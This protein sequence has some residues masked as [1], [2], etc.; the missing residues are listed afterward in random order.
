MTN[1]ALISCQMMRSLRFFILGTFLILLHFWGSAQH[2][3]DLINYKVSEYK[4]HNQNWAVSQS[5]DRWMYFANTDG[6]LVFNGNQWQKYVLPEHNIIRAVY[7]HRDRVY[8]G[9]YGAFGYWVRDACGHHSYTSLAHLVP[10]KLLDKE[11]VWHITSDGKDV[12]FQ[13]FSVLLR[14]DGQAIHHVKLPGS[15]MFLQFVNGNKIIQCID[16]GLYEIID[17]NNHR[18]IAH[19]DF[20]IGKTVTAIL[21]QVQDTASWLITTASDGVFMMKNGVI[22]PWNTR[23]QNHFIV[24]QINKC[25]ITD[26][27]QTVMGTIRDGIL[28]FDPNGSLLYHFNTS[29]GLQN[30]TVLAIL[31]DRDGDLW[32]SQVICGH[33]E[34][35]FSIKGHTAEKISSV[36]GGWFTLP[37]ADNIMLQGTYTGLV[38]FK[39]KGN[40]WIF[41]N[42]IGQYPDP[43]KK[44][45]HQS[46][47][48]FWVAGP[49]TGLRLI[50]INHDFSKVEN[51]VNY[52][53]NLG[54]RNEQNVEINL[55]NDKL[56]VFDG[57]YH[58]SYDETKDRFVLDPELNA[59]TEPCQIRVLGDTLLTKIY[60]DH[61]VFI[62]QAGQKRNF[63]FI[64]NKDY[65]NIC[66]IDSNTVGLCLSEGYAIVNLDFLSKPT[67]KAD[68][69]FSLVWP[70]DGSC[71]AVSER[72]KIQL[73][74]SRNSGVIYFHT[75]EFK[76]HS[77][78]FSRLKPLDTLW[79]PI[80]GD[81]KFAFNHLPYGNYTFEVKY[82]N[83]VYK[84]EFEI[85]AP[86]YLSKWAFLLYAF[87]TIVLIWWMK[88]MFD[89]QLTRQKLRLEQENVRMLRERMI[90]MENDRLYQDNIAKSKDLANATM[91]LIQKNELIQEIKD[92]LI[93][94]RK[95]G[96]QT[97]TA[98]DFRNMMNQ[99]NENLTV[100]DD[101]N[102]FDANF[103]EVHAD[104]LGKLK[105]EYTQLTADDLKLAAYIRMNLSS[106][107]IAPLFNISIRGLENKRY[108]LRKKMNLPM[109]T[110]LTDFF[111]NYL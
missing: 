47:N 92:E 84:I 58:Y 10:N 35:T 36:T 53:K 33:N 46:G 72:E 52:G 6:L 39:K 22:K 26:Q 29:N 85:A 3:P 75:P 95:S 78:Y 83:D 14:Y 73:P 19:T 55:L 7:C 103:E 51:V 45:I 8:T 49:N 111:E 32:A 48:K 110:N 50:T 12:Y 37:I 11:E 34:G 31:Q 42:K 30:N 76:L 28:V 93:Q 97:L 80:G 63:P 20:F 2:I 99:I 104:F 57:M 86:W 61:L 107:E 67:P 54:I 56:M 74:Y 79:N 9:A 70:S 101:K 68:M 81:G 87:L 100:Q 69:V 13:S 23:F 94:I 108:R 17:N 96:D 109:D 98:H 5:P 18:K 106:K 4:A 90:E 62:N 66:L 40:E 43:V 1:F 15:I 38:V 102:L 105:K 59:T 88:L 27:G 65:H 24:S 41:S 89:R 60:S 82:N 25:F 21:P 71:T 16:S 44:V 64:V 91:H 77:T